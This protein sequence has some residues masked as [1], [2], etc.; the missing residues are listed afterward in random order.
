MRLSI[1]T[2]DGFN[3]IDTFLIFHV[4]NRVRHADWIVELC[5]PTHSVVSMNGVTITPLIPLELAGKADAVVIGSGT[6]TRVIARDQGLM[7][8]LHLDPE[9]QLIA[10]Q[11]SGALI[12]AQLGLLGTQ[13]VCTD[14]KTATYPEAAKLNIVD[15]AFH[16]QGNIATAGGC[17]SSHYLATWLISRLVGSAEAEA[18]LRYVVPVGEEEDYIARALR[19]VSPSVDSAT[20]K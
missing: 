16:C 4:L 3:E 2:F 14:R 7:R 15:S 11:C 1:L 8:R 19:T 18:A 6:Q 5:G 10:S 17:L 12:L 9:N 13:T 20:T